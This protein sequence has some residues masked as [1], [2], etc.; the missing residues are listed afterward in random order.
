[1]FTD[2][3]NVQQ[4]DDPQHHVETVDHVTSTARGWVQ[5]ESETNKKRYHCETVK[6]I[7]FT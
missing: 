1:M 3:K 7:P 2:G 6:Q 5:P 4:A